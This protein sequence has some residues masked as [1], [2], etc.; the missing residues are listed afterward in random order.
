MLT[1]LKRV[2]NFALTDFYRNKGMSLAAIFVLSITILLVT[3]L[4][5]VHGI[6][7]FLVSSLQNKIDIT[8]YFVSDAAD[9]DILQVKQDLVQNIPAIKSIDYVSKDQALAIFTQNH[10]DSSIFSRALT[11]V[12]DN[13]FLPALNITTSGDTAQYQQIADFLQQPQY[14]ALISNVDFSQ[15]KDTIEKVFAITS[16]IDRVGLGLGIFLILVAILVVFNTVK[17]VIDSSKEEIS[18]MRIVGASAWFVR[19][20]FIIEG[21]LFGVLSFIICFVATLL[22]AYFLTPV[23]SVIM[24]G[25]SLFGY[26]LSSLFLIIVIQLGTGVG[27]GVIASFIVVRKYLRI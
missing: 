20:P 4:F 16:G 13:P 1:N 18:T 25:F 12:G 19:A 6:N 3:G 21:A 23:L 11:E 17:L 8:A 26:F 10:Q 7:K 5:F 2:T 9:Q 22:S 27:L 15:K 14:A 24:P